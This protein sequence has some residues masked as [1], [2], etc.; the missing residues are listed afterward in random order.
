VLKSLQDN[1]F[2]DFSVVDE[3]NDA[4]SG[5][6]FASEDSQHSVLATN[7]VTGFVLVHQFPSTIFDFSAPATGAPNSSQS[8]TFRM[9]AT[10]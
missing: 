1:G 2:G 7:V 5:L 8:P 10:R 4:H 3:I 6:L 9:W